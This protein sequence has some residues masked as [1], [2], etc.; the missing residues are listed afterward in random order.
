MT[1]VFLSYPR[2]NTIKV[3]G[4][5]LPNTVV[6]THRVLSGGHFA[7]GAHWAIPRWSALRSPTGRA[8]PTSAP[9]TASRAPCTSSATRRVPPRWPRVHELRSRSGAGLELLLRLLLARLPACER[10][11]SR[12]AVPHASRPCGAATRRPPLVTRAAQE[13]DWSICR[14]VAMPLC[15]CAAMSL[16]RYVATPLCRYASMS[17]RRYVSLP[18]RRCAARC[19]RAWV[20]AAR[21]AHV[22]VAV[23]R[24]SLYW[25][26][27]VCGTS[28]SPVNF[29]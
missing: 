15:R 21:S 26:G 4:R 6:P 18:L 11:R 1:C 19:P 24:C 28:S 13:V 27:D 14:Y 7:M 29:C 17:L 22:C 12:P 8:P 5:R 10:A 9:R 2:Q 20:M 25:G 16:R 3:A 23:Q